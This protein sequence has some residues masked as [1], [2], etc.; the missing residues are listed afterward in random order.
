MTMVSAEKVP[1]PTLDKLAKVAT[2]SLAIGE[3]LDWLE[4]EGFVLA[5]YHKHEPADFDDL[6]EPEHE[7]QEHGCYRVINP[8]KN[9]RLE[10]DTE[11]TCRMNGVRL[12]QAQTGGPERLLPRYFEIDLAAVDRERRAL[13]DAIRQGAPDA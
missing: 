2:T 4:A 11:E 13:L 1:T 9:G 5:Q 7:D 6:P 12:Y 3:F 8:R 10:W